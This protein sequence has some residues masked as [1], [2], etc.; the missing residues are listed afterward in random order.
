MRR[1][2]AAQPGQPTC[3]ATTY[4]FPLALAFQIRLGLEVL[5][6]RAPDDE[7]AGVASVNREA[8]AEVARP[9]QLLLLPPEALTPP[10]AAAIAADATSAQDMAAVSYELVGG[11]DASLWVPADALLLL[12]PSRAATRAGEEPGPL[13]VAVK[14]L[15]ERLNC[16]AFST[17]EEE[18][19]EEGEEDTSRSPAEEGRVRLRGHAKA[20]LQCLEAWGWVVLVVPVQ[21]WAEL[22]AADVEE[23]WR[24][25]GT[26][27]EALGIAAARPSPS[28]LLW[29]SG[30]LADL[31][32]V[33]EAQEG[34]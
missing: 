17:G 24:P 3:Q 15:D 21:L 2:Q 12:Y 9:P 6:A 13:R 22:R 34:L 26:Q 16:C 28:Q 33:A 4:S 20:E 23:G 11:A 32:R 10:A 14:A 18:G 31:A 1:K 29:L 7:Q 25:E 8:G 27:G 19:E 30:E 5:A